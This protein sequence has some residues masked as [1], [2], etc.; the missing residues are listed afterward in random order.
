MLSLPALLHLVNSSG[1]PGLP[2]PRIRGTL[3]ALCQPPRQIGHAEIPACR[4]LTQS[5]LNN[6]TKKPSLFGV[7][8]SNISTS[9]RWLQVK[10]VIDYQSV[11]GRVGVVSYLR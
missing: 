3:P 6:F 10:N 5:V 11:R 7:P 9:L 1:M 2:P 4:F 8:R